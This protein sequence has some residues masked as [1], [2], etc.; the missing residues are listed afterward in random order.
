VVTINLSVKIVTYHTFD[1]INM[2]SS[3][4]IETI[5]ADLVRSFKTG[6][7]RSYE[8]RLG[9]LQ[10]VRRFVLENEQ[11]ISK[12]LNDDLHRAQ[13]EA[14]ALEVGTA[15]S[16]IDYMIANLRSWM[17]PEYTPAPGVFAPASSSIVHEPYG[18]CLVIGAFNYPFA[19]S[20]S[21]RHS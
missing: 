10:A 11:A 20:V 15:V 5:H 16:E 13:F 21:W 9:Q 14:I 19:L 3:T 17:Q 18:L 12:A 8:H 4:E 1:T 2:S 6:K 7:T